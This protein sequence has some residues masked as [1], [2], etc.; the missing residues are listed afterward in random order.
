MPSPQGRIRATRVIGSIV[1]RMLVTL[2]VLSVGRVDLGASPKNWKTGELVGVD[3]IDNHYEYRILVSRDV[4]TGGDSK[5]IS[6]DV[7]SLVRFCINGRSIYLVDKAGKVHKMRYELQQLLPP[8]PPP[9]KAS[10]PH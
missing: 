10:A 1:P 7:G 9:P 6:L 5:F 4:Y 8:A 2:A 3:R